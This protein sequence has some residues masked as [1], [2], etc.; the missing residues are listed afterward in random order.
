MTELL[1]V[2]PR[3]IY[4]TLCYCRLGGTLADFSRAF[5]R[6]CQNVKTRK[7]VHCAL[8][9]VNE[10]VGRL[11]AARVM[12]ARSV[13]RTRFFVDVRVYAATLP[14]PGWSSCW[15]FRQVSA[16]ARPTQCVCVA[17]MKLCQRCVHCSRS[18]GYGYVNRGP[19][20]KPR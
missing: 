4:T 20:S 7:T 8:H 10:T 16:S 1:A 9:L 18:A 17:S 14:P 19:F 5:D 6:V 12:P 2:C 3:C 15:R 13:C 11:Q